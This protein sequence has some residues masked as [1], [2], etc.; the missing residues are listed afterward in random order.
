MLGAAGV[1]LGFLGPSEVWGQ[2]AGGGLESGEQ[3]D[4]VNPRVGEALSPVHAADT[5]RAQTCTDTS[6]RTGRTPPTPAVVHASTHTHAH[7]HR[8]AQTSTH[9]PWLTLPKPAEWD[10]H[11][12]SRTHAHSH[13]CAHTCTLN[14]LHPTSTWTG[15]PRHRQPHTPASHTVTHGRTCPCV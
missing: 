11:I 6:T 9:A 1:A 4:R 2:W 8:H 3:D 10:T 5:G 12:R 7:S 15:V 13:W 14:H